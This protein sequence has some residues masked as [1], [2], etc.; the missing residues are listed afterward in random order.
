VAEQ[1]RT[2]ANLDARAALQQ[3]FSVASKPWHRWVF[4]HLAAC[5]GDRILEVGCGTGELWAQN[6]D[7]LDPS[8]L[9]VLSDASAAMVEAARRKTGGVDVVKARVEALP[10]DDAAFDI[11]IASHMLYHVDD[12]VR[13]ITEIARVLAPDGRLVATT[14]GSKHMR[15]LDELSARWRGA[16]PGLPLAERFGLENAADQLRPVFTAIEVE[17]YED[18]LEVT[19]ADAVLAYIRSLDAP[20]LTPRQEAGF[21]V[22]IRSVIDRVGILRVDK[23]TGVVRGTREEVR[24]ADRER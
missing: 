17:R 7:R 4:D 15:Q 2:T 5:D 10:F 1:Y 3:R 24:A 9:V 12:R 19:D 18:H 14:I 20:Q 23:D 6:A 11:V 13:A 22:E 8:W 21:L 16:P